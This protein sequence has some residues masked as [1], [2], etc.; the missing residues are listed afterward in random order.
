MPVSRKLVFF[1]Q[2][3]LDSAHHT[4]AD[5]TL[6]SLLYLGER[7]FSSIVVKSHLW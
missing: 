1:V 5:V 6:S 3:M 7:Y 4:F 2:L